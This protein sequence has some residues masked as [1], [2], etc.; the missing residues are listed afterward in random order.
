MGGQIMN[1]LIRLLPKEYKQ[2]VELAQR[3]I[4]QLDTKEERKAALEYGIAMMEDGKVEVGEWS[5]FGSKLG[6]LGKHSTAYPF[7]L[8]VEKDE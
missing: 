8:K 5:K 3:I 1:W 2:M 7:E 6:I 4:S